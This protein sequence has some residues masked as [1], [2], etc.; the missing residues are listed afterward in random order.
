MMSSTDPQNGT[1]SEMSNEGAEN[2]EKKI[3][4]GDEGELLVSDSEELGAG[5][6]RD[7]ETHE[8]PFSIALVQSE[9]H[10]LDEAPLRFLP[11]TH[12]EH[13]RRLRTELM[14]RH[15]YQNPNSLGVAVVS[16]NAGDGRSL[17]ALELAI[18]F[19][20]LGRP[21]LLIDA[22]MRTPIARRIFG[23]QIHR[24]LAQA[25]ATGD[26]PEVNIVN[27][28]PTLSILGA[29]D[30]AGFNPTELLANK[31]FQRLIEST[32]SLFDFIVIDTPP[33][34]AYSDAQ[35]ISA[36]V[37]RVITLHRTPTNTYRD[38]RKMLGGLTRSGAEILGA[39]LNKKG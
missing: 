15:G 30:E 31:R 22:D 27:N 25:L 5:T 6:R 28:Y 4:G 26:S 12:G 16:P 21:T 19:A 36:V 33:F 20:Q 18:S 11:T 37:G 1:D 23:R 3:P 29:G 13:I 35:V 10:I 34:N 9:R 17:L 32:R 38:T 14:L 24:G 7:K 2:V 39:V 8:T